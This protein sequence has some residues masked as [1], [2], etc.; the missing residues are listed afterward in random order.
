VYETH[1]LYSNQGAVLLGLFSDRAAAA[2]AVEQYHIIW[3]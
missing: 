3:R 2:A 1:Y